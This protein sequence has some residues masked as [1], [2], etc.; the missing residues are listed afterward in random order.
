MSSISFSL[1]A[2][3]LTNGDILVQT[4]TIY[5]YNLADMTYLTQ[6][7]LVSYASN[8]TG[9][10]YTINVGNSTATQ[11]LLF[12]LGITVVVSHLDYFLAVA[13]RPFDPKYQYQ[14]FSSPTVNI[15]TSSSNISQT[16]TPSYPAVTASNGDI[17]FVSPGVPYLYSDASKFWNVLTSSNG[18]TVFINPNTL[19]GQVPLLQLSTVCAKQRLK[20]LLFLEPSLL[21]H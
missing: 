2:L 7:G 3:A 17:L 20:L 1:P 12:N 9:G 5:L 15:S 4:N 13:K 16:I 8:S 14:F 18:Q 6:N 21:Q 19:L 11:T 10:S